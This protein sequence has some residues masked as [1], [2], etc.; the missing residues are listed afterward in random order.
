[1]VRAAARRTIRAKLLAS[2]PLFLFFF[3]DF[4]RRLEGPLQL[5]RLTCSPDDDMWVHTAI[6]F[7]F[8]VLIQV[9]HRGPFLF[10]LKR[11]PALSAFQSLACMHV[12]G[13]VK[14]S[15]QVAV[16]RSLI[17]CCLRC[18]TPGSLMEHPG[19]ARD[20]SLSRNEGDSKCDVINP[21]L[22]ARPP[23]WLNQTCLRALQSGAKRD[24]SWYSHPC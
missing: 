1:M 11:A 23:L 19:I 22:V 13:A 4:C 6:S 9:L 12:N 5:R 18:G 3:R 10:S 8:I 16:L 2:W 14:T 24:M 21:H 20:E 15:I 17:S 7:F